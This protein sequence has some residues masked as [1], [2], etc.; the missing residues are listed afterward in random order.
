[1]ADDRIDGYAAGILAIARAEGQ[2]ERVSDELFRVSRSFDQSAELRDALTDPAVPADRKRG[3][4]ADLLGPRA[5]ELVTGLVSFLV[6]QGHARDLP[7]IA[8]RL[9]EQ[10]AAAER[11]AVAEVR[12]AV[13]LDEGTVARLEQALGQATGKRVEVKTVIDPAV[14]G[15]VVTTIGD[16]VIDGSLRSRL[17]SIRTALQEG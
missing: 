11:K 16:T 10:A 4:V 1:M 5:S 7:A 12:T 17:D 13:E 9:A 14:I 6:G 2:L 8:T 3:I 15:G